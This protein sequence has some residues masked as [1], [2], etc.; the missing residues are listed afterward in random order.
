MKKMTKILVPTDL[1]EV[2][3]AAMEYARQIAAQSRAHIY[4]IHIIDGDSPAG[5]S[6]RPESEN[7]P[8]SCACSLQ[9]KLEGSFFDQLYRH[10]N[11]VC[12]IRRGDP[13]AEILK[14]AAEEK[15][16]LIVMATHGTGYLI[17][18]I[19]GSVAERILQH[20]DVAI[21]LVRPKQIHSLTQDRKECHL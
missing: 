8:L 10:E 4:L 11:I 20:P 1:S 6:E 3:F 15:I 7:S 5:G 21:L 13:S 19:V 18:T 16:D 12:V 9:H 17:D 2:S 14:F